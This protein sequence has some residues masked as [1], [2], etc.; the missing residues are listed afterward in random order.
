[1]EQHERVLVVVQQRELALAGVARLDLAGVVVARS[2]N[3][4]TT[5]VP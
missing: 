1:M 5:R 2:V 3:I 4:C